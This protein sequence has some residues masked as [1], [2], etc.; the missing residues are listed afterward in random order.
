MKKLVL[1]LIICV[2]GLNV[3]SQDNNYHYFVTKS[4]SDKIAEECLYGGGYSLT[5]FY[6]ANKQ[7]LSGSDIFSG[8]GE[9][10]LK[11]LY[12]YPEYAENFIR[13]V[14]DIWGYKGLK[15]IGFDDN[16]ILRSKDI[17]SLII[18]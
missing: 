11:E 6:E 5:I 16:E 17:I 2:F 9:E 3:L 18:D 4:M 12:K 8:K 10:I 15:N 7:L 14:Y 13:K 1:L